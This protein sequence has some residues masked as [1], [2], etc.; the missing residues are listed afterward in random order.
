MKI[1]LDE[2]VRKALGFELPGHFVRTVQTTGWS[3]ISNGRLLVLMAGHGFDVLVTCDQ[4]IE[5][6][7]PPQSTS[8]AGGVDRSQ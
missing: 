7:Q 2:S 4:N 1:L 5:Y 6:Q 3:E 8:R